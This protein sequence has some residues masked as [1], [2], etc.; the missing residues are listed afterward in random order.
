MTCVYLCNC[1]TVKLSV[2]NYLADKSENLDNALRFVTFLTWHFKERKKLRF[3]DFEEKPKNVF[4]NNAKN[5]KLYGSLGHL[6]VHGLDQFRH[7]LKKHL[8]GLT[9]LQSAP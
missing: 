6:T 5:A 2:S 3:L 1:F 9:A 7:D 8:F 4:S